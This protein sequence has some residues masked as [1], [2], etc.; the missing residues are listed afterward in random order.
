MSK[1]SFQSIIKLYYNNQIKGSRSVSNKNENV[2][3]KLKRSIG[4]NSTFHEDSINEYSMSSIF[5]NSYKNIVSLKKTNS[6]LF[7][8]IKNN[9]NK[10]LKS[11]NISSSFS[12]HSN[13]FSSLNKK[14]LIITKILNKIKIDDEKKD[15]YNEN[16]LNIFDYRTKYLKQYNKEII[17]NNQINNKTNIFN[18]NNKNE[19]YK[20]LQESKKKY[21]NFF[22][23]Y[24]Y[25]ID[26]IKGEKIIDIL[27]LKKILKYQNEILSVSNKINE[28]LTNEIILLNNKVNKN[29]ISNYL[30]SK[31]ESKLN[32]LKMKK[33]NQI[34]INEINKENIK[35]IDNKNELKLKIYY[36]ENEIEDLTKLLDK[37]KVY[38][39]EYYKLKKIIEKKNEE[40]KNIIYNNNEELNH[41]NA[42]IELYKE[43]ILSLNNKKE[44]INQDCIFQ[45]KLIE[46]NKNLL[47]TIFRLNEIIHMKDEELSIYIEKYYSQKH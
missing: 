28:L 1:G 44:N 13:S 36:L 38:Y 17:K 4:L 11:N 19:E 6:T 27:S 2:P 42:Q 12:N 39:E 22:G 31:I 15:L 18:D 7:K 32:N 33:K 3:G 14:E 47:S 8:A 45:N 16:R 26:L 29:Y 30:N 5:K 43:K 10:S 41:K 21:I 40:I 46:E 25:D 37:N 23:K 9:N 20:Y 34:N 24:F 35:I